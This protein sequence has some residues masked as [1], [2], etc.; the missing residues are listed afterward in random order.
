MP[1]SS[2]RFPTRAS[3]NAQYASGKP[4]HCAIFEPAP[5]EVSA[6]ELRKTRDSAQPHRAIENLRRI[7][8]SGR[9]HCQRHVAERFPDKLRR[10]RRICQT[11][12]V[13][14]RS[15]QLNLAFLPASI[16]ALDLERSRTLSRRLKCCRR[17]QMSELFLDACFRRTFSQ[18]RR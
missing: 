8:C 4:N 2:R 14:L 9:R 12:P 6:L 18:R 10:S 13:A 15:R 16:P 11:V 5:R 1:S 3:L 7:H 17:T